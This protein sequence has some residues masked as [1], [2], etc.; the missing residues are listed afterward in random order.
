MNIVIALMKMA[1]KVVHRSSAITR[2]RMDLKNLFIRRPWCTVEVD[3]NREA[4]TGSEVFDP[5]SL[6]DSDF[7]DIKSL[8]SIEELFGARVHLGH[9]AGAW[10]PH[11]KEYIFGTRA[12]VHIIDLDSTLQHL[13][14]ALNVASHIAYRGGIILFVNERPQFE[15]DTQKAARECAQYFV[16]GKW[17]PGTFTNS[18]KLLDTLR[19]PD[20]VLFFSLPPSKTAITES[21]MCAIPTIGIVDTDCNPKYITYPIPGNDDTPSA[22]QLYLRLFSEAICNARQKRIEADMVTQEG[23]EPLPSDDVYNPGIRDH[24]SL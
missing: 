18:Y 17:R 22:V 21:L 5:K 16:A 1:S 10:M 2:K 19:L 9:K 11:M 3:S 14:R 12:G 8:T 7:F 20:L 6:K 24:I 15:I 23:N 13:L 4:K